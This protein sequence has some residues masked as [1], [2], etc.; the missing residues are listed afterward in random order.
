MNFEFKN[1]EHSNN[2]EKK[3]CKGEG[4][5]TREKAEKLTKSLVEKIEEIEEL[6]YKV[7][8]TETGELKL[9]K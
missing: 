2:C 3:P 9:V 1:C 6:G 4:C 7:K 5:E 8:R